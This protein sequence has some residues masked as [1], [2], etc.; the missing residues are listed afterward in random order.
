M[1]Y[2]FFRE[3][4]GPARL[5]NLRSLGLKIYLPA[6]AVN[7]GHMFDADGIEGGDELGGDCV[8]D[9][10]IIDAQI[11]RP[12]AGGDDGVMVCHLGVIDDPG[13]EREFGEVERRDLFAPY[14][15]E[16]FHDLGNAQF[17]IFAKIT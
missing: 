14:G 7:R 11:T 3:E 16:L 13:G 15:L 1:A 10:L 2:L 4:N 17:Q 6:D 9:E 5:N 8:I 12:D